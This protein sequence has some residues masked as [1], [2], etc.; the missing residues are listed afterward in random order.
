MC[1]AYPA[2]VFFL[3]MEFGRNISDIGV[4]PDDSRGS[5]KTGY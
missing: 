1:G 2:G 5:K 3:G 4:D